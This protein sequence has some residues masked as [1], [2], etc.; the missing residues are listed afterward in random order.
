MDNG[1]K[2]ELNND[3]DIYQ[4][5]KEFFLEKIKLLEEKEIGGNKDEK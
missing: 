4:K 1:N 3:S 2:Y 5:L